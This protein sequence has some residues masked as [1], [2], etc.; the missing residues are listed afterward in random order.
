MVRALLRGNRFRKLLGV[1]AVLGV[2]A[3]GAV[4]VRRERARRDYTPTEV[5]DHLRRRY[6]E[7]L[8]VQREAQAGVW[9]S[10]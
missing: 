10:E 9:G 4:L 3:T 7:A 2:A 6:A 1:S 8:A 5:R